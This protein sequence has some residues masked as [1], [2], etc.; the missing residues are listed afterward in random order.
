[1][2]AFR[3]WNPN[4]TFTG[5]IITAWGT[6]G[7]SRETIARVNPCI[8]CEIMHRVLFADGCFIRNWWVIVIKGLTVLSF[9]KMFTTPHNTLSPRNCNSTYFK[10]GDIK[11]IAHFKVLKHKRLVIS[12]LLNII[13]KKISHEK[14]FDFLL[15]FLFDNFKSS[16]N[17]ENLK[18]NQGQWPQAFIPSIMNWNGHPEK[19]E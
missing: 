1:M 3:T 9:F 4:S 5:K 2:G 13:L 14:D 18:I 8:L 11:P 17:L 19:W 7:K 12:I 10:I 16:L 15:T 6:F